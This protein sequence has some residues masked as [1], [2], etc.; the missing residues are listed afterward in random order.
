MNSITYK[1]FIHNTIL[2][3]YI[4][5]TRNKSLSIF[6]FGQKI[7]TQSIL[8]VW[9]SKA[10]IRMAN[11]TSISIQTENWTMKQILYIDLKPGFFSYK[12]LTL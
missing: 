9:T 12:T 7:S 5:S 8:K 4:S 1:I 11:F 6:Y 2:I 10:Y 3:R